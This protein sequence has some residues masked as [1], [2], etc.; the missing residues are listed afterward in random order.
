[1]GKSEPKEDKLRCYF[2]HFEDLTDDL[3]QY[4]R[5]V[6][7]PKAE[8]ES[9]PL[10]CAGHSLGGLVAA[11]VVAAHQSVFTALIL[12]SAAIDVEWTP[13]LRCTSWRHIR[14]ASDLMS[15]DRS[16]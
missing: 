2:E 11:L 10:I 14:F 12:N 4:V 16:M 3:W 7:Q 1:M 5:E 9:L 13:I 8:S 15:I 6:V